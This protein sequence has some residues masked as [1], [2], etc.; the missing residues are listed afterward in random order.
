[1]LIGLGAGQKFTQWF[2]YDFL[3]NNPVW[4]P[5]VVLILIGLLIEFA[6]ERRN[7]S[8]MKVTPITA[9]M[10]FLIVLVL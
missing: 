3:L 8:T 1:M 4:I 5:L 2:V 10:S 7:Y 9:V 6:S